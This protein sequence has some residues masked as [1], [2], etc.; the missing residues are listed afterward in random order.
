MLPYL[1]AKKSVYICIYV[2]MSHVVQVTTVYNIFCYVQSRAYV[3]DEILHTE[4]EDGIEKLQDAIK[5]CLSYKNSFVQRKEMLPTYFKNP[6]VPLVEWS[7]QSELI[8]SRLD[9][10]IARL[11]TIVVSF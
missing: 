11:H 5:I 8:F 2:C 1:V 10:F 4:P 6:E 9:R 7:F 3:S